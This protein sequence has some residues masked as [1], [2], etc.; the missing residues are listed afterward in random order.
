MYYFCLSF[1]ALFASNSQH[2]LFY[3]YSCLVL[4][5]NFV[6]TWGDPYYLGLTGLEVLGPNSQ[7]IPLS[8]NMLTVGAI[9]ACSFWTVQLNC[10]WLWSL[11]F[12]CSLCLLFSQRHVQRISMI[13]QST[14]TMTEPLT[15]ECYFGCVLS[16][17]KD[18]GGS[19][20]LEFSD[21]KSNCF[22]T[23]CSPCRDFFSFDLFHCRPLWN[24]DMKWPIWLVSR[25]GLEQIFVHTSLMF[26]Q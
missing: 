1:G 7:R 15:S 22:C 24:N 5:L 16:F 19:N 8:Y 11:C 17:K 10:C 21:G 9:F 2:P 6:S 3:F 26:R 4:Q 20:E 23:L 14:K 25:G 18:G 12:K 13:F